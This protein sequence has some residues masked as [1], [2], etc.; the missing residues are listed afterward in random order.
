MITEKQIQNILDRIGLANEEAKTLL[1]KTYEQY[2]VIFNYIETS[3]ADVFSVYEIQYLEFASFIILTSFYEAGILE[4][5]LDELI[6]LDEEVLGLMEK[7]RSFNLEGHLN[8]VYDELKQ[9]DLLEFVIEYIYEEE[10]E[11]PI[12]SKDLM[13]SFL[14]ALIRTSEID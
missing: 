6:I 3:Y 11:T 10:T 8:I 14:Q 1:T 2:P 4:V 7:E 5:D 13:A 12:L 9:K